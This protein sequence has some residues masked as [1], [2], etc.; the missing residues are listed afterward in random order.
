MNTN[1]VAYCA[2]TFEVTHQPFTR[3]TGECLQ[4]QEEDSGER[5]RVQEFAHTDE[6]IYTD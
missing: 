1:S 2:Y 5:H 6:C 3:N 4:K